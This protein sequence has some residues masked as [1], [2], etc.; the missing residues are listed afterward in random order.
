[1]VDDDINWLSGFSN[2]DFSL[3]IIARPCPS[4]AIRWRCALRAGWTQNQNEIPYLAGFVVADGSMRVAVRRTKGRNDN[5]N[6]ALCIG[7]DTSDMDVII[8]VRN[9][10]LSHGIKAPETHSFNSNG[11][12]MNRLEV[13]KFLD[14]K[15]V[16]ELITPY[17][18]GKKR[19][20]A[21]IMLNGVIPIFE[22]G[23]HLTKEG[24]IRVMELRDV[25]VLSKKKDSVQFNASYFKKLWEME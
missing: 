11:V 16:L 6:F 10:L 13:T 21:E 23:G 2:G 5:Y 14:I 7:V 20:Q 12:A 1:M 15:K 18:V 25:M 19:I 22:K 17:M 24:F 3:S 4:N 9:I 8:K